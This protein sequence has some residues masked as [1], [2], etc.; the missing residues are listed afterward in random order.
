VIHNL[1]QLS[2]SSVERL[3]T[4]G[5]SILSGCLFSEKSITHRKN[6]VTIIHRKG[7]I[8]AKKLFVR[9]YISRFLIVVH[10]EQASP[11]RLKRVDKIV[12]AQI[13]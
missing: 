5:G 7:D 6:I 8:P 4:V 13:P 11:C 3:S 10:N 2:Q 12:V 9:A 1:C